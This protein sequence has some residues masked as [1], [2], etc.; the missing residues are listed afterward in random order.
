MKS[1]ENNSQNNEEE[2]PN[3]EEQSHIPTPEFT[4][5]D[6]E[7][8]EDFKVFDEGGGVAQGDAFEE[9]ESTDDKEV[10]GPKKKKQ[11]KS[12]ESSEQDGDEKT[13]EDE[14]FDDANSA[15]NNIPEGDDP[16]E[17]KQ[18]DGF[19]KDLGLP[20]PRV[21]KPFIKGQFE[22][23]EETVSVAYIKNM[24]L[25]MSNE[26]HVRRLNSL[27]SRSQDID[28]GLTIQSRDKQFHEGTWLVF[29]TVAYLRFDPMI[30]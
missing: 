14:E 25:D 7:L 4:S 19:A 9:E 28:G 8:P 29:L 12:D 3:N 13:E 20:A 30:K 2:N 1:Q 24:V 18:K 11:E 5:E 27:D 10:S 22:K 15:Y 26:E 17:L 23:Y 21:G 6:G 16:I